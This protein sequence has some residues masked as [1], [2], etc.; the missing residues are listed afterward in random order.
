MLKIQIAG[1]WEPEDFIAVLRSVESIYYKFPKNPADSQRSHPLM[2]WPV[3]PSFFSYTEE[4]DK[5][6]DWLLSEARAVT[7]PSERISIRS[8]EYSSPGE[9]NFRGL[10]KALDSVRG[11]LTDIHD[12][13]M[14]RDL[15]RKQ[16]EIKTEIMAESL[17]VKKLE[18]A[19]K[20]CELNDDFGDHLDQRALELLSRDMDDIARLSY[21]G[22]ITGIKDDLQ[23]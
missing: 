2:L 22:K 18:T 13:C 3:R 16:E 10:G 1:Y 20:W 4:I 11:I 12:Y 7:R 9:I 15:K 8:I 21:E 14:Y 6:N 23:S 19:R 17:K 5:I